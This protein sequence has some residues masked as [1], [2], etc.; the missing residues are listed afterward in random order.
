MKTK[1][2][3][4]VQAAIL[5]MAFTMNNAFA[6]T[7]IKVED[8]ITDK[9]KLKVDV[10]VTYSNSDN[11]NFAVGESVLVQTGT[12]SFVQIP[13]SIS[14]QRT[15][16][17][18]LIGTLGIRYGLTDKAEIYSRTSYQYSQ[19]RSSDSNGTYQYNE[20]RLSDTWLGVNYQ[21]KKDTETPAVL[22]FAEVAL[23]ER[24]PDKL[25]SFQS[26][27]VGVT[28]YKV[29]D[30]V[31]LSLN[32]AYRMSRASKQGENRYKSGNF[33]VISP[34][35]AFAVN[36]KITLNGGVQWIYKNADKYNDKQNTHNQ[37]STDMLWGLTY[38]PSK[39]NIFDLSVKSNI[40][41]QK[42]AD[43]NFKWQHQF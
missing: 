22:G 14:E 17:D 42:G 10:G 29:I 6:D 23:A 37:T 5:A 15:N 28:T 34:A 13:S 2:C 31:L 38:S 33:L 7:P 18:H 43:L 25:R 1:T 20:N 26:A 41:G 30:P 36:D 40:S 8:A 21:F 32:L 3:L 4:T 24:Y 39:D 27:M 11:Q 35:V 19:I 12:N 16:Q 9:G